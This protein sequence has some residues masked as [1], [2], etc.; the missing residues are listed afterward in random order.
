MPGPLS[1]RGTTPYLPAQRSPV[2]T[3]LEWWSASGEGEGRGPDFYQAAN[4]RVCWPIPGID[5]YPFNVTRLCSTTN[6]VNSS[7]HLRLQTLQYHCF[8]WDLERRLAG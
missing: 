7:I 4:D 8:V 2:I 3:Y 5:A 1:D 6:I